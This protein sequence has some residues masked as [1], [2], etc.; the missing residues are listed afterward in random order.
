MSNCAD[1]T[2]LPPD[3]R[4]REVAAILAAGI[5]RLRHSSALSSENAEKNLPESPPD[6]LEVPTETRLSVRVG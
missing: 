6:G 5:S 2:R 3:E 1:V 4:F